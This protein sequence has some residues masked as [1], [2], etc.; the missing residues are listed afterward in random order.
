M[1]ILSILSPTGINIKVA[2]IYKN[3]TTFYF[4]FKRQQKEP[5]F[6][7]TTQKKHHISFKEQITLLKQRNLIIENE[8]TAEFFLQTIS[9]N[10]F[11]SYRFPFLKDPNQCKETYKENTKFQDIEK[12]ILADSEISMLIFNILREIELTLRTQIS[13][14]FTKQDPFFHIYHKNFS[15]KPQKK[16]TLL[17]ETLLNL[18]QNLKFP[19]NYE[20]T[21]FTS[22]FIDKI[23]NR[24]NNSKSSCEYCKKYTCNNKNH[25]QNFWSAIENIDFGNLINIYEF[26]NQTKEK[27]SI[28]NFF[29]INTPSYLTKIL[30]DLK[31]LR[32][33]IAHHDK[34][35]TRY[36]FTRL[37]TESISFIKSNN[38]N[39]ILFTDFL[40]KLKE[41]ITKIN[42]SNKFTHLINIFNKINSIILNNLKSIYKQN[43]IF[44]ISDLPSILTPLTTI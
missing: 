39:S 18:I 40:N 30:S 2:N 35:I 8:K 42:Q 1:V 23:D 25:F 41:H 11:S 19:N 16:E 3:I 9:Y 5:F 15:T 33:I 31:R 6:T 10:R 32:N 20:P 29:N 13:Y 37:K 44:D 27:Q 28:A 26:S 24:T 14:H 12:I 22:A 4:D 34:I 21:S 38:S 43:Y 36:K 7:M 17:K